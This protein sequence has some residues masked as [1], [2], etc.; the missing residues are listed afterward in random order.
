MIVVVATAVG[1]LSVKLRRGRLTRLAALELRHLWVIWATIAV[2][3]VIFQIRLPFVTETVV[4]TVHVGTYVASFGFLW[5]NRHIPGAVAIGLGAG[6]N[7]LAIF[8]NGGVMPAD[9]TAWAR[10]G[11]PVAADGQ[12]ENSNTTTDARLAFLGD[13]F[14]IPASWP[15]SNVFS[16]GDVVIVLAATYLAHSWCCRPTTSNAWAAPSPDELVDDSPPVAV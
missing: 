10:A 16:I 2:Q 12:F 9:P 7:A 11:L 13:V 5:L 3:T 6:A 1:L 4:E 8:A 15:L 14:H